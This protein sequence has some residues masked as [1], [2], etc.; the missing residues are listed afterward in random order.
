MGN[1]NG[2]P[3]PAGYPLYLILAKFFQLLPV[4]SLAFRTNL[5]SAVCTVAAA[6]LLFDL[7]REQTKENLF[8]DS[9]ALF[10]SLAYGLSPAVWAQALVTEVYALHGLLV[11]LCF[12]FFFRKNVFGGEWSRGIVFGLAAAN[13]ITSILLFPLLFLYGDRKKIPP[14]ALGALGGL[15]LYLTLPLRALASPPVN[16]GNPSTLRGFWELVSGSIYRD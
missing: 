10:G 14:R 13:H 11:I 4:G 2:V 9:L 7:I 16:W 3:H 5:F 1:V 12:Y 15:L 8:S 6:L